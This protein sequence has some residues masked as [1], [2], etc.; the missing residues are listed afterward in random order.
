MPPVVPARDAHHLPVIAEVDLPR[1]AVARSPRSRPSSQTSR[2]R[3]RRTGGR[4]APTSATVPAASCPITSGG[5]RRPDEPSYPCTSLPQMPQAAMLISNSPG[6]GTGRG[7][8]VVTSSLLY[9]ES[10]RAFIAEKNTSRLGYSEG[11][12]ITKAQPRLPPPR[13]SLP[14]VANCM[15]EVPS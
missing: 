9:S 2:D 6:P 4:R 13:T 7:I 5:I 12:D 15:F 11:R 3:R 1:A 10:R 8:S 14:I